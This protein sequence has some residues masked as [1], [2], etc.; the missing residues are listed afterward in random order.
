MF[1]ESSRIYSNGQ[2]ILDETVRRINELQTAGELKDGDYAFLTYLL[3]K[4]ELSYK[5]LSITTLELFVDGMSSVKYFIILPM[6][7]LLNILHWHVDIYGDLS[8]KVLY[9]WDGMG[10][11]R[12]L[13]KLPGT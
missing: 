6:I 5:D 11:E 3:G 8:V 9:I 10:L 7:Y 4:K 13:E 12:L 2:Q 1:N